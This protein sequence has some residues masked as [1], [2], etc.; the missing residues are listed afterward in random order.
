MLLALILLHEMPFSLYWLQAFYYF[1]AMSILALG[2]SWITSSVNIFMRDT[3][4]IVGVILRLGFWSTPIFWDLGI[5]PEKV[6]FFIKL[7]PMFYIVQGYRESFLYF[8]PFWHHPAMTLYF[9]GVTGLVFVL[10][11]TIFLRLRPHFAD[12]L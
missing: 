6:Q 7:N 12:V 2:I 5:M 9:W 3:A 10:G 4:Q 1:F 8:V 11:A